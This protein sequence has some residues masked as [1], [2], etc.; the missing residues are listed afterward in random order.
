MFVPDSE[1]LKAPFRETLAE[2]ALRLQ[3]VLDTEFLSSVIFF[4]PLT[5]DTL[6]VRDTDRPKA[7][8]SPNPCKFIRT[9]ARLSELVQNRGPFEPRLTKIEPHDAEEQIRQRNCGQ[10]FDNCPNHGQY[11]RPIRIK[12]PI[13]EPL[14]SEGWERC[15]WSVSDV[16]SVSMRFNIYNYRAVAR[17]VKWV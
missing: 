2:A 8:S 12:M 11:I 15:L 3:C 13:C 9:R 5:P 4:P 10:E 17:A 14:R 1:L 7:L 6:S 16:A